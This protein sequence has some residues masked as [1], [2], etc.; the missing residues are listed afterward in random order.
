MLQKTKTSPSRLLAKESTLLKQSLSQLYKF[1]Q[2]P[3]GLH[4]S[5]GSS[6]LLM[7]ILTSFVVSLFLIVSSESVVNSLK[8][9]RYKLHRHSF[10]SQNEALLQEIAAGLNASSIV[11]DCEG[12]R[13]RKFDL[14]ERHINSSASQA[15]K[16]IIQCDFRSIKDSSY[17][18][19]YSGR[20]SL[21]PGVDKCRRSTVT[22][23]AIS[24]CTLFKDKNFMVI[25]LA[26]TTQPGRGHSNKNKVIRDQARIRI[27]LERKNDN[28]LTESNNDALFKNCP[29]IRINEGAWIKFKCNKDDEMTPLVTNISPALFERSKQNIIEVQ[30]DTYRNKNNCSGKP[31]QCIYSKVP[32]FSSTPASP[33]NGGFKT[34]K[35]DLG[36]NR[37][38]YVIMYED[39]MDS[40]SSTSIDYND[41]IIEITLEREVIVKDSTFSN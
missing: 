36:N 17:E 39:Y 25:D 32:D 40:E 10:H 13:F 21:S 14:K 24:R 28:I 8:E 41:Y 12:K 37:Y 30:V 5:R 15:E 9:S 7:V 2:R 3:H 4:T 35:I 27:D 1:F 22:T 23:V 18:E 34:R 38:R 26:L 19:L 11:V 6:A 16:Q 29:K 33:K 20:L 31:D